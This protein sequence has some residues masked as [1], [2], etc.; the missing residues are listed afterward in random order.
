MK[1]IIILFSLSVFAVAFTG[2]KKFLDEKPQTEIAST[3][4]WKSED[5]IK[6]GLAAMYDGLQATFDNNYVLY[7]DV[8]TDEVDVN[9]YG[10]DAFVV[11]AL[12]ATTG[13]ADWTN[14]YT[15]IARANL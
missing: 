8:R 1:K 2:C 4:F 6:T 5:D 15:T 14:F 10:D 7:G 9:Q 11:N 13:A 12:S 3:E